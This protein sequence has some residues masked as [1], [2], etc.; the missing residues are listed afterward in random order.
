MVRPPLTQ[1]DRD[2]VPT[3]AFFT[4]TALCDAVGSSLDAL[5]P[6]PEPQRPSA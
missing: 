1:P 4:A 5:S 2:R 6:A 3:P